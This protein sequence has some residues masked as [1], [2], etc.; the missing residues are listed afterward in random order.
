MSSPSIN[1]SA[2]HSIPSVPVLPGAKKK[3]T[4]QKILKGLGVFA[5]AVHRTGIVLTGILPFSSRGI[6]LNLAFAPLLIPIRLI[7]AAC[8][9]DKFTDKM[10]EYMDRDW[11]GGIQDF[12]IDLESPKNDD[13]RK[14]VVEENFRYVAYMYKGFHVQRGSE[15]GVVLSSDY[16][17]LRCSDELKQQLNAIEDKLKNKLGF[18]VDEC[19][20]YYHTETGNTF[21]L[22]YDRERNEIIVCFMGI[23]NHTHF[24][25]SGK[26][27]E[28]VGSAAGC[29]IAVDWMGGIPAS[30]KQAIKIGRILKK[31][32]KR[33]ELTPV[34]V[35]HSHGGGMAQA[36]AVANGIKGIAFNSRPM[37]AGVR[38]YIGQARIAKNAKY[39]TTFSGRGDWLSGNRLINTLAI[40]F[41][42][43]TGIP[44]PRSV[45]IGYHLPDMPDCN[46]NVN[47]VCIH[48]AFS[49]LKDMP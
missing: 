5:D 43:I 36:G 34:L 45:G 16:E 25:I 4:G 12:Y 30:T 6:V 44:V 40:L 3:T 2:S 22:I 9:K 21:N 14:Q 29:A 19:G 27:Q 38:R 13:L 32:T 35:G 28:R 42:R 37:G 41:E 18:K 47:H 20:N 7:Q 10:N 31:A 33:T 11:N 24:S 26:D 48:D 1:L 15:K 8:S 49:I 17:H 46:A 23:G 39:V